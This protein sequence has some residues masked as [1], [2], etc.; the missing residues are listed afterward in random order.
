MVTGSSGLQ[1]AGASDWEFRYRAMLFGLIISLGFALF[2]VDHQP[3]A[4]SLADW[5]AVHAHTTSDRAG[6]LILL[7]ATALMSLAAFTRTW[8]S[9]YLDATVVYASTVRADDLVADG[10]YRHVRNPLYLANILMI[11]AIG[12][13][14]SA[15]GFVVA[16]IA[17]VIF[18]YRLILREEA[19]LGATRGA[20]YAAYRAAVPR[21]LPSPWPRVPASGRRARWASGLRAEGWYWGFAL[22]LGVLTAT[23]SVLLFWIVLAAAIGLFWLARTRARRPE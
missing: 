3:V 2:A 21:L 14:M 22:A 16:T 10:P 5:L 19:D 1:H 13:L 17:M 7:A 12:S 23:E 15:T 8:A 11:V 6:R 9:S 4:A 18:C 20:A